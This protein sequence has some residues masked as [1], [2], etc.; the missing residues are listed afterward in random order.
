MVQ[1]VP[2]VSVYDRTTS[3]LDIRCTTQ[4][5]GA[6]NTHTTTGSLPRCCLSARPKKSVPAAEESPRQ[7]LLG[8]AKASLIQATKFD[9]GGVSA[10]S[11]DKALDRSRPAAE[12]PKLT[13]SWVYLPLQTGTRTDISRYQL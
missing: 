2:D 4:P 13:Y 1:L 10:G 8:R 5:H 3:C 12:A 11:V 6:G 7:P 9:G